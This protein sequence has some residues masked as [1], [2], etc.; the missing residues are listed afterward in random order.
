VSGLAAFLVLRRLWLTLR[1]TLAYRGRFP[2][3]KLVRLYWKAAGMI[4]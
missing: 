3:H 1:M 2:R 4:R